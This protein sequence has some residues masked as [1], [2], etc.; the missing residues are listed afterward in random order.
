MAE[1]IRAAGEKITNVHLADSH[2]GLPGFGNIDFG[3]V[4]QALRAINY[5][6]AYAL[7]TLVIPDQDFIN[8]HCYESVI[9]NI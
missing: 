5:K 8:N 9:K 2:R 1:A 4:G 3:A 7:E 6:G